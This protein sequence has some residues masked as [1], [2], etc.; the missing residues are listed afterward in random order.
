MSR[1]RILYSDSARDD[2][3]AAIGMI[4][5]ITLAAALYR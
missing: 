2:I 4:F 1:F 3:S 5:L